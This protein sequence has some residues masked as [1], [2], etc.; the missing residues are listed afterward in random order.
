MKIWKT[1]VCVK[2]TPADE[3]AALPFEL[4]S[5]PSDNIFDRVGTLQRSGFNPLCSGPDVSDWMHPY[6]L[7]YAATATS[8]G[9]SAYSQREGWR[10]S[11]RP[12]L[13]RS[14]QYEANNRSRTRVMATYSSRSSA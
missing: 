4:D 8:S 7:G 10:R 12:V 5:I 14:R 9:G 6:L 2:W 1:A 3:R 11:S 13:V